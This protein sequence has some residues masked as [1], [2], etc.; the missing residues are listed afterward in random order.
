MISDELR[1]RNVPGRA[2]RIAASRVFYAMRFDVDRGAWRRASTG[3]VDLVAAVKVAARWKR[4]ADRARTLRVADVRRPESVRAKPPTARRSGKARVD[5]AGR[6][7]ADAPEVPAS[8]LAGL[9]DDYI[10]FRRNSADGP[11]D[12]HLAETRRL[13]RRLLL[14]TGWREA[15][16]IEL[17]EWQAAMASLAASDV[18]LPAGARVRTPRS[19]DARSPS[20]PMADLERSRRGR[21]ASQRLANNTLN[22]YRAAWRAFTRWAHNAGELDKNPLAGLVRYRTKGFERRRRFALSVEAFRKLFES[23]SAS[24][25]TRAGLDGQARAMLYLVAVCSGFRRGE[26]A[27]LEP[28]SI[29]R[30]ADGRVVA[31]LPAW[32]TKNGEAATQPLLPDVEAAMGWIASRPTRTPLWPGLGDLDAAVMLRADARKAGVSTSLA[33]GRRLD[34][35]CL[36]R[37]FG[38]WLVTEYRVHPKTAMELMRHS[39]MELTM[40]LYTDVDAEDLGASI[41]RPVGAANPRKLA[42]VEGDG[43]GVAEAR[44]ADGIAAKPIPSASNGERGADCESD[45]TAQGPEPQLRALGLGDARQSRGPDR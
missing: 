19:T 2:F 17:G 28:A 42:P 18:A 9:I 12:R 30:G 15:R 16:E 34:F 21:E 3:E 11:K 32:A 24:D 10:A 14:E 6:P 35:H 8:P 33:D 25:V 29:R 36:R 45:P 39:T 23:V 22:H 31:H 27:A 13:L 4:E 38:T 26:L 5:V 1:Q 40:A 43:M 20:S 44:A 7:D 41:G 37:T